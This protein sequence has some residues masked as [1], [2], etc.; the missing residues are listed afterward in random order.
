M[1]RVYSGGALLVQLE[2]VAGKDVYHAERRQ[3]ALL[4]RSS[5]AAVLLRHRVSR[6]F[7]VLHWQVCHGL[8]RMRLR[9][10][11]RAWDS[12]DLQSSSVKCAFELEKSGSLL[13]PDSRTKVTAVFLA[14][15]SQADS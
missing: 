3:G 5:R 10:G 15:H 8:S 7:C 9:H 12:P 4:S 11:G 13:R 2:S 6:N 1:R 14:S